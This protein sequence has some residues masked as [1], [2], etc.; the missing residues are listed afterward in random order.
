MFK[1]EYA[2]QGN[3]S[4]EWKLWNRITERVTLVFEP[5]LHLL[6]ILHLLLGIS[7][8]NLSFRVNRL[9]RI[10]YLFLC[11]VLTSIVCINLVYRVVAKTN[12][13]GPSLVP[14]HARLCSK[15]RLFKICHLNSNWECGMDLVDTLCGKCILCQLGL[16]CLFHFHQMIFLSRDAYW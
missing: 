12:S 11:T 10:F 7:I 14:V 4:P 3:L 2:T 1:D 5:S 13:R 15:T 6:S 9:L 16:Y 8:F